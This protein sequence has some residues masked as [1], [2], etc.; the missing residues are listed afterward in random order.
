MKL[1]SYLHNGHEQLALLVSDVLYDTDAL[2]PELPSSM[3]MFL[4]YWEDC[5]PLALNCQRAIEDGRISAARGID[6]SGW[7]GSPPFRC[8]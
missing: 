5:Y 2:H 4:N 7:T 6:A 8:P 1:V 3:N